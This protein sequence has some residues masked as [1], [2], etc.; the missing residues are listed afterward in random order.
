MRRRAQLAVMCLLDSDVYRELERGECRS[1]RSRI[2]A[3]VIRA[4]R[5]LY[6]DVFLQPAWHPEAALDRIARRR[7]D[8]L[9]NLAY[10]GTAEESA[11]VARLETCGV[12]FTGSGSSALALTNDKART[13][14]VLKRHGIRV[15]RWVELPVGRPRSLSRLRPPFLVKPAVYGGSSYGIHANSVVSSQ[16]EALACAARLWKRFREPAV[17]DEFIVG[18]EF[19]V[20]AVEVARTGKFSSVNVTESLFPQAKR[21]WGLKTQ[22]VRSNNRVRV[23]QGIRTALVERRSREYR[24]LCVLA[25]L[26]APACELRGYLTLDVRV[27][28]EG[29]HF[30]VDVNANPGL[31]AEGH[32]WRRP[33]F[34]Y[35]LRQIVLSA[36][37][38]GP[39]CR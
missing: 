20:G 9:F 36:L 24:Q 32:I 26:I 27:D 3:G 30:V 13:R 8:V 28:S 17:C 4:L 5:E 37:A 1:S 33:S 35:N 34:E 29:K 16:C 31:S 21:G 23:A 15:P 22:S 12:P 38:A 25:D 39:R 11:F 2:D 18:S 10:S 19:R 14:R 6:S 7:P